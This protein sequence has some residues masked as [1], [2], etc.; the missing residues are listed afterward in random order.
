MLLACGLAEQPDFSEKVQSNF[1]PIYYFVGEKDLKF[2]QMAV[3][4]YL[5]Y[6]IIENAGHNAHAENP[7]K[8]AE[9]LTALLKNHSLSI[10]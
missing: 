7:Q 9:K 6:T 8:F 10:K 3:D 1:L 5:N 2:K 4:N